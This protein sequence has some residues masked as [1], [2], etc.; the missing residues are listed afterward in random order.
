MIRLP[1]VKGA[2]RHVTEGWCG[3]GDAGVKRVAA[4]RCGLECARLCR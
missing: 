3:G 4:T 1:G 2:V